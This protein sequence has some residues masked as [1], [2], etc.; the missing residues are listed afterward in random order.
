MH[1]RYILYMGTE[2]RTEG[3]TD[4][5]KDGRKDGKP[6]TIMSLRKGGGQKGVPHLKHSLS[7]AIRTSS[8]ILNCRLLSATLILT[9]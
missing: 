3:R 5:R 7:Q 9:S 2:G 4:G 1:T 6:K 8:M